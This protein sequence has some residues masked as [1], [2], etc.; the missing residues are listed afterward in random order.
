MMWIIEKL[1]N[2]FV[3]DAQAAARRADPERCRRAAQAPRYSGGPDYEDSE[4]ARRF[5]TSKNENDPR[6]SVQGADGDLLNNVD[7]AIGEWRRARGERADV[8]SFTS[9]A[10]QLL[11]LLKGRA[12]F[13]QIGEEGHYEPPTRGTAHLTAERALRVVENA[14]ASG[15]SMNYETI[16]AVIQLAEQAGIYHARRSL[17][18]HGALRDYPADDDVPF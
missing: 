2:L 7:V 1:A 5:F 17:N 16:D 9:Y 15:E 10:P 4:A 13:V 11:D 6:Y 12:V 8:D 3:T 14:T 18:R